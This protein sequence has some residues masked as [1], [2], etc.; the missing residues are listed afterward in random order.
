MYTPEIHSYVL[1]NKIQPRV[2]ALKKIDGLGYILTGTLYAENPM[3]CVRAY[4]LSKRWLS[5]SDEEADNIIKSMNST[6]TTYVWFHESF[7]ITYPGVMVELSGEQS[8]ILGL[9]H[10]RRVDS[11]GQ[12]HN[13][14]IV[15]SSELLAQLYMEGLNIEPKTMSVPIED[16]SVIKL[17]DAIMYIKITGTLPRKV[18]TQ[19][20]DK[21]FLE[22]F[23]DVDSAPLKKLVETLIEEFESVPPKKVSWIQP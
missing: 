12:V 17:K 10:N 11:N 4:D 6:N 22:E 21:T 16:P 18:I 23:E 13:T 1:N 3:G 20:L 15:V 2:L 5:I 7:S 19:K 9:Q 14:E 8:H